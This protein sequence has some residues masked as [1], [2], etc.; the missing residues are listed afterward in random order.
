M[1]SQGCVKI[2]LSS[3]MSI[4]KAQYLALAGKV[5]QT[6]HQNATYKS[7]TLKTLFLIVFVRK[8][9]FPFW[10]AL[11]FQR[12]RQSFLEGPCLIELTAGFNLST[13]EKIIVVHFSKHLLIGL[14]VKL[15]NAPTC[16][17]ARQQNFVL[18][19]FGSPIFRK[20]FRVFASSV[21]DEW[22]LQT[23]NGFTVRFHH[24]LIL[25]DLYYTLAMVSECQEESCHTGHSSTWV[26]CFTPAG[27]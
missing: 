11:T 24:C 1:G 14:A 20:T 25:S 18:D 9:S 22:F 13:V 27:F 5:L 21:T 17:P 23:P 3:Q 7:W 4:D 2:R 26:V 10:W 15:S 8:A 12:K 19:S 6:L 16:L